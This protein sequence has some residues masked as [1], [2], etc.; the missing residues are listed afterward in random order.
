MV[1]VKPLNVGFHD[2]DQVENNCLVLLNI[3]SLFGILL[4]LDEL[5]PEVIDEHRLDLEL[6]FETLSL[7]LHEK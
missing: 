3:D 5:G 6:L 2:P 7:D 4:C 1:L